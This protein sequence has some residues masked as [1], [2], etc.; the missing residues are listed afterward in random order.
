MACREVWWATRPRPGT[1]FRRF[2]EVACRRPTPTV[3]SSRAASVHA[4]AMAEGF[5][6]IGVEDDA[7]TAVTQLA[8][9]TLILPWL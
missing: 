7:W 2:Q 8:V 3:E 1:G 5:P 9:F 4:S 6:V